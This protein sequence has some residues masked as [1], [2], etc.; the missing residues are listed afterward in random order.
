MKIFRMIGASEYSLVFVMFLAA[1]VFF[2]SMTFLTLAFTKKENT[3]DSGTDRG[4]VSHVEHHLRI[5][6]HS[7]R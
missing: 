2:L 7:L 5:V 3:H 6:G 1:L 4:R